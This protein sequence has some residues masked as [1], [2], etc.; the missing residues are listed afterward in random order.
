MG[1][2]SGGCGVKQFLQDRCQ[3]AFADADSLP[4]AMERINRPIDQVAF[5]VDGNVSLFNLPS[6]MHD[7]WSGGG[8]GG[9]NGTSSTREPRFED[10]VKILARQVQQYLR[11][12]SLVV[13]CFDEPEATPEAK[14]EEQVI[15][16]RKRRAPPLCS[17]DL[18]AYPTAD[19]FALDTLRDA[20][21]CKPFME[22]RCTRQRF[23]D[24]V[25]RELK[26]YLVQCD[27][28]LLDGRALVVFDGIDPRGCDR[29]GGVER[30]PTISSTSD[31]PFGLLRRQ[32]EGEAD[33]K[34]CSVDA[35]VRQIRPNITLIMQ[36]TVD[37]D[38]I[39]IALLQHGRRVVSETDNREVMTVVM[40]KQRKKD[41]VDRAW[42]TSHLLVVV[43]LLYESL[44]RQTL[45]RWLDSSTPTSRQIVM[46][47]L[48]FTWALGGCDFV[49]D[50][51]RSAKVLIETL[52]RAIA[53]NGDPTSRYHALTDPFKALACCTDLSQTLGL[54]REAGCA[55][56]RA[57]WVM[58]YW[59]CGEFENDRTK[60]AEWGFMTFGA[61]AVD[62]L[63]AP[64]SRQ[65]GD[66]ALAAFLSSR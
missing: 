64:N 5:I 53:S 42:R 21:S 40:M 65:K 7:A 66:R 54:G 29:P 2:K 47:M 35:H 55:V 59:N 38:S 57:L 51:P 24:A 11:F 20:P 12:S 50:A 26:E 60:L 25:I 17:D 23:I 10:Y 61:E 49:H 52:M 3:S 15:R 56:R 45:S 62:Q 14:K 34:L 63:K 48:A 33:R 39:P 13:Y 1:L 36:V 4:Q 31:A 8:A 9:L 32:A 37:T 41:G 58:V 46:N 6:S 27:G 18:Y 28:R 16:D 30:R 44:Q 22:N 43:P 19:D